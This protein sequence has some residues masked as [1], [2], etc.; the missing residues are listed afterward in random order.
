MSPYGSVQLALL[1]KHALQTQPPD[2]LPEKLK[3]DGKNSGLEPQPLRA[4]IFAMILFSYS[5][6][7]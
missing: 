6:Y 5:P 4:C 1:I 7:Y 2:S 3:T